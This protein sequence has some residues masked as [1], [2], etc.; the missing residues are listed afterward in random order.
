[1]LKFVTPREAVS[2]IKNGDHVWSNAFLALANPIE[3][4]SAIGERVRETGEPRN[5]TFCCSS[6]F[7]DWKEG[8]PNEEFIRR[9]A[10]KSVVL[11]HYS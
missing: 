7:G 2:C 5:L 9:G 6:G 3:L 1:M 4:Q 11:G 8:T 10:V